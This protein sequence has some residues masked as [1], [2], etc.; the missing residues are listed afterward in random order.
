MQ[1]SSQEIERL[2]MKKLVKKDKIDA[3]MF[4]LA[5]GLR[6]L[7]PIPHFPPVLLK[8]Y[9]FRRPTVLSL[10]AMIVQNTWLLPPPNRV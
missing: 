10:P 7:L 8:F 1:T 9:R 2:V 5:I 3:R 4:E 6:E